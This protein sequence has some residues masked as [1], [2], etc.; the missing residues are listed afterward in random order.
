MHLEETCAIYVFVRPWVRRG[1]R[2]ENASCKGLL[3]STW[4]S[5]LRRVE[6]WDSMMYHASWGNLR[7]V[8][9]C[10]ALGELCCLLNCKA[11]GESRVKTRWCIMNLKETCAMCL[12][13]RPW[14]RLESRLEN[15]YC[16]H[17]LCLLCCKA[18]GGS[19]NKTRWCTM[20]LEEACAFC[21]F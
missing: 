5:G 1:L 7:Y 17:L 21:L 3:L 20:Y 18:F 9:T 10:K 6:G 2:L 16:E 15:V 12:L 13:V 4:L 11:F 14:V 8:L 19:R